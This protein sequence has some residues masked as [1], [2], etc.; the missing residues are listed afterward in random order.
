M[1]RNGS[2]AL[3]Q[4]LHRFGAGGERA[5]GMNG[6]VSKE[7]VLTREMGKLQCEATSGARP[8]W[9]SVAPSIL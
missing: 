6:W 5:E 4:R 2:L 1:H 7:N 8:L 3:A 9:A